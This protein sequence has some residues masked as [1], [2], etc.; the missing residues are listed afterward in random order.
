MIIVDMSQVMIS[1]LYASLQ[2]TKDGEVSEDFIRRMVIT[3]LLK[4]KRDFGRKYG[5]LVLAYDSKASWRKNVFPYYKAN[6]K[7][8]R[9]S[10]GMDWK[11][12]FS[13]FDNI[14]DETKE[15]LPYKTIE[16]Y[17]AE[18]DDVI[19]TL[20]RTYGSSQ[21]VLIVS[22]DK[23]FNQLQDYPL[24]E[25]FSPTKKKFLRCADPVDFLRRQ[26]I[27]GDDGDG[28]PNILSDDSCLAEGRRQKPIFEKKLETWVK[29]KRPE[30][31]CSSE[32]VRKNFSRNTI[33]IDLS[34]TPKEIQEDVLRQYMT[35]KVSNQRSVY[36]YLASHGLTG[37]IDRLSD[38]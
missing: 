4:Y 26:V 10:T 31:F 33:M 38:F 22:G 36:K 28:V 24:V 1:N 11:M 25:Q 8:H 12:I 35:T 32:E 7:K 37:L 14:R 30:E 13:A 20:A 29:V 19:G 6:R 2:I 27:C 9:E 34:Q 3:S 18:A 16:V 21:P 23:D 17:G 15:S 5:E